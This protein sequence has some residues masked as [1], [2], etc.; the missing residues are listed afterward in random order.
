MGSDG[1]ERQIQ[2]KAPG[3]EEEATGLVYTSIYFDPPPQ[4]QHPEKLQ[5]AMQQFQQETQELHS[6]YR[7]NCHLFMQ[8]LQNARP[9]TRQYVALTLV[10]D[11]GRTVPAPSVVQPLY[12]KQLNT[13]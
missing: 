13:V 12:C 6:Q 3:S 7:Y 8:E 1:K 2:L 10:T 4:N 9:G 5:L 11:N